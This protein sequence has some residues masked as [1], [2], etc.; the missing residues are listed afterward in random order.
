MPF[1]PL[2]SVK[3]DLLTP[4]HAR[5]ELVRRDLDRAAEARARRL[6]RLDRPAGD[7]PGHALPDRLLQRPFDELP[8]VDQPPAHDHPR[9]AEPRDDV[10]DADAEV[11]AQTFQRP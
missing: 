6:A 4:D 10:R 2:S 5:E 3:D 8:A 9:H 7:A 11:P 1:T